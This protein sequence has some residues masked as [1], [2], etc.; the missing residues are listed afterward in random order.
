MQSWQFYLLLFS[1]W[2]STYLSNSKTVGIPESVIGILFWLG[3]GIA[4]CLSAVGVL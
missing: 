2:H 3:S 4:L 1:L